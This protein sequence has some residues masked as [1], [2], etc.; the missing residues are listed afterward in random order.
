MSMLL[1]VKNIMS[2][3]PLMAKGME[4]MMMKGLEKDS[5]CEA[6]TM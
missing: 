2:T 5:N 3:T 6:M 4:N 1:P